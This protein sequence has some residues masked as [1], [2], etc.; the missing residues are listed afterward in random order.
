MVYEGHHVPQMGDDAGLQP[1]RT[2]LAWNRT[3]IV[4]ALAFGIL[5]LHAARVGIAFIVIFLLGLL[6]AIVLA[7]SPTF[8]RRRSHCATELMSGRHRFMP[9]FP[10]MALSAVASALALC[11]F[12]L[13]LTRG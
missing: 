12:I 6:T 7:L 3:L 2:G 10:L 1:E 13:I 5:G 11:S 4:L 8:A 9:P